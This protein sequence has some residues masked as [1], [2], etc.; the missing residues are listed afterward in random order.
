MMTFYL[1]VTEI[2]CVTAART[3]PSLNR[4]DL[5]QYFPI[6]LASIVA[7]ILSCDALT[8]FTLALIL[9]WHQIFLVT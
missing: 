1:I 9:I 6:S 4:A 7:T 2:Y 3:Y 5:N 8:A